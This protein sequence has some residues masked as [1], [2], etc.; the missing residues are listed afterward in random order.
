MKN[1]FFNS[2][3]NIFE[4]EI[5]SF[6]SVKVTLANI[7]IILVV[8]FLA[9]LLL[10]LI[11]KAIFRNKPKDIYEI[12][13]LYAVYQIIKYIVWVITIAIVLE[14][15]GFS[16]TV[17]LAGSA[18]LIVGIGLGLQQTFND[19]VSGIILLYEKSIK[20]GDVLEI[21]GDI[22]RIKKIGLRT[23]VGINRDEIAIIIP[24]SSIT[25]SKVIN[26]SHQSKK[27][28]F[29][30]NVRVAYGSDANLV[31]RVLKESAIEHPEVSDRETIN[32]RL[33]D[34]GDS[35]LDFQLLFYSNKIFNIERIKA[36]I[37]LIILRKFKENN[38]SIPYPQMDLH[39][40]SSNIEK[41][42]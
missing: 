5:I 7:V 25:T 3:N 16:I 1:S 27:T 35:S 33:S 41:R 30:I 2:I 6:S 31:M 20:V 37:R 8:I 14:S 34:F 36:E 18:A 28:R 23:S 22:V 12:G 40:K 38:I 24:N 10:W 26:W 9:R 29:R 13:N 21:D 42:P 39:F 15:I 4:F 32:A 17:I 11:R 19:I